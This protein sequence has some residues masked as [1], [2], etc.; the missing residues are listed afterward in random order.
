MSQ[1]NKPTKQE[2]PMTD[3]I[4]IP[5]GYAMRAKKPNRP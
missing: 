5:P 4:Q 2:Q 1:T 3:E